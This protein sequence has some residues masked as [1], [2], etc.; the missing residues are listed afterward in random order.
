M[1]K[2]IIHPTTLLLNFVLSLQLSLSQPQQRHVERLVEALIV[3]HGRKTLA[4]LY[5]H[6]V[7]APDESAVSDFLRVS[8]WSAHAMTTSVSTFGIRDL[9]RRGA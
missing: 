2:L 8:P 6:W 1:I 3:G 7:D 4:Q 5:R 9:L